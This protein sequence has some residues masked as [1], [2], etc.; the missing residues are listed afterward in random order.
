MEKEAGVLQFEKTNK[1]KKT[2][3]TKPQ[4]IKSKNILL[5]F[6]PRLIECIGF[7]CYCH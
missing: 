4:T 6:F 3:T 5:F 1:Q 2:N 7:Y